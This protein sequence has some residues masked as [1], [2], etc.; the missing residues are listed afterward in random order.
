MNFYRNRTN[1]AA[2]AFLQITSRFR[3]LKPI[4][5]WHGYFAMTT[6][7]LVH[8][9]LFLAPGPLSRYTSREDEYH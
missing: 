7:V 5:C 3:V 4:G 9:S 8:I 1:V 6:A 2:V